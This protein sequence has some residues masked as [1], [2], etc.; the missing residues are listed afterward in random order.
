MTPVTVFFRTLTRSSAICLGAAAIFL[1]P[2]LE[3]RGESRAIVGAL[4]APREAA[5]D[6]LIAALKD[7][8]AAVRR[9]AIAALAELNS[10]RAA[11][12]IAALLKDENADIRATAANAL[13]ELNDSSAVDALIAAMART[14]SSPNIPCLVPEMALAPSP[15]RGR[16][17]IYLPP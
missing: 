1:H 17:S 10:Q 13:G 6:G 11:G 14:P 16:H 3:W 2:S 8:D 7:T 4:Q 12:P 9:Q 5:V 15:C